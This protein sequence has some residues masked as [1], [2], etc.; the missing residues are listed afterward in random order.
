MNELRNLKRVGNNRQWIRVLLSTSVNAFTDNP[1]QESIA[2]SN[3]YMQLLLGTLWLSIDSYTVLLNSFPSVALSYIFRTWPWYINLGILTKE[4]A[5]RYSYKSTVF[6][7]IL[8]PTFTCWACSCSGSIAD[9][10][11]VHVLLHLSQTTRF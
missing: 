6:Y 2:L 1:S 5:Q 4:V 7:Y 3:K 8:F 9:P 10:L 11:S